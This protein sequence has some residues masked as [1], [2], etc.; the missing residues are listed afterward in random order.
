M[1][2]NEGRMTE[3]GMQKQAPRMHRY[4]GRWLHLAL[5]LLI[6][7]LAVA[8]AGQRAQGGVLDNLDSRLQDAGAGSVAA[9]V[10]VEAEQ[11]SALRAITFTQGVAQAVATTDPAAINRLVTPLQANS[12]VPMVDIVR[13]DG[14]V[15]FAVRSK[16]APRPAASHRGMSAIGQSVREARGPRGG[17]F[18]E[19]VIFKTGPAFVTIGPLMI[20]NKAV[21]VV[22]VMTP[23]A[24]VLGRISQQVRADLTAYTGDGV[25]IATTALADPPTLDR[26]TARRLIG[27][28][29]VVRRYIHGDDREALGRL[30]VDHQPDAVLGVSLTDNSPATG[31]AVMLFAALGLIATVTIMATFWARIA[32]RERQ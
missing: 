19:V 21:G 22:L 27:G 9:L 25:P 28:G 3:P 10:T 24:D 18:T 20:G 31:R 30:I 32:N 23:L 1:A 26:D 13:P 7:V 6:A 14:Q 4:R 16:G 8:W 5:G 11:L 29:A 2:G 15:L 17:R 12:N